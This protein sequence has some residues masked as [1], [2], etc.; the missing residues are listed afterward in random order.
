VVCAWVRDGCVRYAVDIAGIRGYTARVVGIR[1]RES[2]ANSQ[3]VGV[4]V[5]VGGVTLRFG[6]FIHCV[7]Y[8]W[9]RRRGHWKS[10][11]LSG[12]RRWFFVVW[13][14][15]WSK[16]SRLLSQCIYLTKRVP[17]DDY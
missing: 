3:W 6:P 13:M 2:E 8:K 17:K 11:L 12:K 10:I 1:E 9:L 4:E 5:D 14:Y 15:T 16:V 7:G